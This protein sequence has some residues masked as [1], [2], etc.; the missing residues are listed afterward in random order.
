MTSG[1]GQDKAGQTGTT[2][3][4]SRPDDTKTEQAGTKNTHVNETNTAGTDLT[5]NH[6]NPLT[7]APHF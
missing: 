2:G 7:V 5:H 6:I 1:Q 4:T 3:V